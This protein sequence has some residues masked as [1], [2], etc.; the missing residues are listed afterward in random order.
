MKREIKAVAAGA[1]TLA[2]GAAGAAL[3]GRSVWSRDTAREV[4]RLKRAEPLPRRRTFEPEDLR[5][6]P[7]PVRRYFEFAL[8]PGQPLVRRARIEHVG[9][10]RTGFDSGWSPFWSIQHYRSTPPGFVWDAC[11]RMAP[12]GTVRVRDSYSGG[13]AVMLGKVAALFP[14]A[15]RRGSRE[16]ASGA[17][18]RFLAES[19]WLPTALLPGDGL[20]WQDVDRSI[21]RATLSDSGHSVS[22]DFHFGDSGGIVRVEGERYRD[23][24]GR[25]VR[26][27]FVGVFE[28]YDDVAEMRIPTEGEVEWDLPEGRLSYWMGRVVSVAYDFA[29]GSTYPPR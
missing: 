9:E 21:A 22:V 20:V 1:V 19:V 5:G 28:D 7:D 10:F 12:F 8:K 26:T 4:A 3:V 14:V 29:D 6:L 11:M 17:L 16:L 2:T 27:P 18:H 15:D 23:V 24:N 25:S 13:H